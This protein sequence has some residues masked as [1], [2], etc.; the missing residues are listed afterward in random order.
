MSW[1]STVTA[2]QIVLSFLA[3]CLIRETMVLVL[4][5]D[6]AGP[7]GWLVNTATEE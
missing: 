6:I 4:P 1:L 3:C 7:G 2:D 5:D